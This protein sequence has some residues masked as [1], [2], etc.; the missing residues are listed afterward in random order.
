MKV[1]KVGEI[2]ARGDE[3]VG[4]RYML[5]EDIWL[6]VEVCVCVCVCVCV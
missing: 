4:K 5:E 2:V 6:G 3:T 1:E